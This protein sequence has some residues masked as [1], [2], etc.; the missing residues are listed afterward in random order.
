M[1]I[2]ATAV[3]GAGRHPPPSF[4]KFD[5]VDE[6][7]LAVLPVPDRDNSSYMQI[8]RHNMGMQRTLRDNESRRK[9]EGA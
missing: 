5:L 1:N 3:H 9:E 6:S 2:T 7:D 8:I 4:A